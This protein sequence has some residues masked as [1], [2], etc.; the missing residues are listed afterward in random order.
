MPDL[1]SIRK[2]FFTNLIN[3]LIINGLTNLLDL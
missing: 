3:Y 2:E 1:S